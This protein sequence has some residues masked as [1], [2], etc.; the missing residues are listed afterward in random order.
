MKKNFA[1]VKTPNAAS[2]N[3]ISKLW[4]LLSAPQL[5]GVT[6]NYGTEEGQGTELAVFKSREAQL[7][8]VIFQILKD[9]APQAMWDI[10]RR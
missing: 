3:V 8:R 1:S 4:R 7:N 5:H 6:E 9:E 10:L 2:S